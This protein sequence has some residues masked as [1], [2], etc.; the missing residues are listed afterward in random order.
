MRKLSV[1]LLM[2][3][4]ALGL[5][6]CKKT[7][8]TVAQFGGEKIQITLNVEDGRHIVT[9][10]NGQVEYQNGDIIYVGDGNTYIGAL[11]CTNGTFTGEVATPTTAYLH[12]YFLGGVGPT[13]GSL[14]MASTTSFNV[15]IADQSSNLPVL[16]Y[17]KVEYIPGQRE[18]TG[19]LYNKCGLVKFVPALATSNPVLISGMH[20]EANIDFANPG[21]TPTGATGAV[22]L[23]SESPTA[24]WAI[25]LPQAAVEN[26]SVTIE[27]YEPTTANVPEVTANM[28]YITTGVNINNTNRV[29]YI[30]AEFSVSDGTKVKFAKGNLQYWGTGN[31]GTLTP[32]WRFA[33]NQ[34]D[35]LGNASHTGNVSH[36][37]YPV[38]TTSDNAKAARDYF[39]WGTSGYNSRYPYLTRHEDSYYAN[40]G[41]STPIAETDY[42][43][44]VYNK[45]KIDNAP[46][47]NWRTLTKTE[48]EYLLSRTKTISGSSK[49]LAG[50]ATVNDIN[51]IIV[52]PDNWDG[53]VDGY[54]TYGSNSFSSNSYTLSAWTTMEEAG[55]LFLPAAGYRDQSGVNNFNTHVYYWSATN[56]G[57]DN[58]YR[59]N[60]S[61]GS[62][63]ISPSGRHYGSCV[64]LVFDVE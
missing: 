13:P 52:L 42:D 62:F 16:S 17:L 2:V 36:T 51:G 56:S 40:S 28:H 61:E 57:S 54:F 53:S 21:I 10:G 39:G 1:V 50:Y 7:A 22:T 38:N 64:R 29:A 11:V 26:A 25:L 43:W 45:S 9:P 3:A 35:C 59:I 23:F 32:K 12:F 55:C 49:R 5:A 58:A 15:N 37:D 4:L 14:A 30:D 27:S 33:D 31:S 63:N 20:T 60:T 47:K 34:Y 8:D 44:G 48:W 18:Y 41:S 46:E 19:I 24:K 6:Q